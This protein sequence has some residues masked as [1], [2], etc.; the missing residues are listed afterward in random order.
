MKPKHDS[1][2]S[3]ISSTLKGNGKG[4][5]NILDK[6]VNNFVIVAFFILFAL[7]FLLGSLIAGGY[8]K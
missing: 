3:K 2:K 8:F 7:I 4:K 6:L 1:G 5:E